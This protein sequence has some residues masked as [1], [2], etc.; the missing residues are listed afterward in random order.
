MKK[1]AAYRIGD[2]AE[3]VGASVDT[4]R[5]YEKID[6]L[7][8]LARAPSGGRVFDDHDITRLRFIRRAQAMN[9]TLAEIGA[10]LELRDRPR[11]SKAAVRDM[12]RTK[13]REIDERVDA[14]LALREELSALVGA[15]PGNG[16]ECPILAGIE[17]PSDAA[18]VG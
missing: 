17:G 12:A 15:C 16:S 10:L 2:A 6:L 9:F 11:R 4:F 14:L 18:G 1:R 7:P 8:R 5:Y 13:V 3:L